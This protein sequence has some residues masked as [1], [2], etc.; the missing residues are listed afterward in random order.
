M[1][2]LV[3]KN[4]NDELLLQ[5]I[6]M[7]YSLTG[8][9]LSVNKA[10]MVEGRLRKRIKLL[11]LE[12]YKSYYDFLS[13]SLEEK[14]IFI[15]LITTNETYFFR[16]DR[17]WDYIEADFLSSWNK[18]SS[19]KK[20]KIW[21]AASSSGEEAYSVA[22][23]CENKKVPYQVLATDISSEILER[24]RL[25]V[26]TGRSV[27]NLKSKKPELFKKYLQ[28]KDDACEIIS[29]LR[30]KVTFEEYNLVQ[31]KI[32]KDRFD[33]V[34]LRNVL[35]YFNRRDQERVVKNIA[36]HM[37]IGAILIIGE[38]ESLYALDVPLEYVAPLIYKKVTP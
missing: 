3:L 4:L 35:I 10:S 8:I 22:I 37:N 6:D 19:G 13:E 21:S 17:V 24:A 38:S 23:C 15:D 1:S 7:A 9:A 25:G 31:P 36:A 11:N 30:S 14:K 5:F 27:E 34:L 28:S 29:L 12:S 26:Y 2:A 16:T 33:L 32:L 20:L 18:N